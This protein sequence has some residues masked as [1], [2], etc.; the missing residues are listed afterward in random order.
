MIAGL[1]MSAGTREGK[2]LG[3]R[4]DLRPNEVQVWSADLD[5]FASREDATGGSLSNDERDRAS[6]FHFERDRKRFI[7]GRQ[8]LRLL[9]GA[10][11]DLEPG[12]LSIRYS[13]H[14]KPELENVRMD[15]RLAFNVSH[16]GPI[17]LFAFV[18]DHRVGV[19]VEQL[20]T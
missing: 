15:S 3:S 20:R 1:Q 19:D 4:L 17:A 10:Y 6:R 8:I 13:A 14:D 12:N 5:A 2:W 7:A 16:S 9:L 18:R 11:L